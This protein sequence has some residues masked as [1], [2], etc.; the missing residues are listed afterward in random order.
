MQAFH[1]AAVGVLAV[2]AEREVV[3]RGPNVL[4]FQLGQQR[5]FQVQLEQ[6]VHKRAQCVKQNMQTVANG[7]KAVGLENITYT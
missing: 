2:A 4:G 3:A 5:R 7:F 1:Q 6:M